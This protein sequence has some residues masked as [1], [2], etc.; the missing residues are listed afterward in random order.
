MKH[1]DNNS[2][3]L[4]ELGAPGLLISTSGWEEDPF[5]SRKPREDPRKALRRHLMVKH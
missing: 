4:M 3:K 1:Q 5:V 2:T